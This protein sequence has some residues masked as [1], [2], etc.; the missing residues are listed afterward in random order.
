M[1][2][3]TFYERCESL[4]AT[5]RGHGRRWKSA[6]AASL[7]IGRASLYRY[8]GEVIVP[9]DVV[10]RLK[11]REAGPKPIRNDYELVSLCARAL[12]D[13]QARIDEKG[14]LIA[15][16]PVSVQRALDL[17]AAKN[18]IDGSQR[19]PTSLEQLV[20]IAQKPMFEWGID[21]SWDVG[22][23]FVVARL[24]QGGEITVECLALAIDGKEPERELDENQGF[25]QLL[26]ICHDRSDGPDV[27]RAWRQI[28]ISHPI[29]DAGWP[30]LLADTPILAG[31]DRLD[32]IV[33]RF[34]ERLPEGM[35]VDGQVPVCK[36]T[37]TILRPELRGYH[38]ESRDPAAIRMARSSDFKKLKYRRGMRYLKRAFRTFWCLPGQAELELERTLSSLGW[39]CTLW[40]K[41]DQVDLVATSPDGKRQIAVDV[42]DHVS[43]ARL[44]VRFKGFNGYERSHDCFLVV[45]DYQSELDRGF[46]ER[47]TTMRA[48]AGNSPVD[49]QTVSGLVAKL[50]GRK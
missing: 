39:T 16:Y 49:I 45:P 26:A 4:F 13:L 33:D 11:E 47:F 44:A 7:G 32:E 48:S 1:D 15:P 5:Q 19:W 46:E 41:F 28:V 14:F 40:P 50:E 38:T 22:E 3:R 43:T 6:A 42:K 2:G 30:L 37:G 25:Q 18:I 8:F 17:G 21:M 34:Y 27:Y 10:A 36:V 23:E 12:K 9:D 20:Q 31:V 24:L 29:L 35:A